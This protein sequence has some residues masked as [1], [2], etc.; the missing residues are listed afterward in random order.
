MADRLRHGGKG[1]FAR[2]LRSRS[3]Q[4]PQLS[5]RDLTFG[6]PIGAA[7]GVSLSPH[8][9]CFTTHEA[10]I[11]VAAVYPVPVAIRAEARSPDVVDQVP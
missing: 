4:W 11:A 1:E 6:A 8:F 7:S 2:A 9:D 10:A 5:A 3:G